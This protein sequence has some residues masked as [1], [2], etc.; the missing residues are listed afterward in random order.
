MNL[1]KYKVKTMYNDKEDFH[2]GSG[3]KGGSSGLLLI[4]L[5]FIVFIII[6]ASYSVLSF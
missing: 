3:G 4:I 6:G 5:L 1:E 2:M